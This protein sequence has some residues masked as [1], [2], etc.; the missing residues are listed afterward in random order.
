VFPRLIPGD[1]SGTGP[2]QKRSGAAIL[3]DRGQ[4]GELERISDYSG[5]EPLRMIHW[6]L[7]ARNNALLVKDFGRQ[8]APPLI[9][10]LDTVSGGTVEDRVSRAA[11]LVRH[12]VH[13]RPV[14]LRLAGRTIPPASG[15]IHGAMLLKDLALHGLD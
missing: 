13:R 5:F 6:K 11:W 4:D 9:I 10:D 15:R 14:G 12:W 7:S 8:T 3:R 1:S 2:D